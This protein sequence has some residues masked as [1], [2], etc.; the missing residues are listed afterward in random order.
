M[1]AADAALLLGAERE[2]GRVL[3]GPIAPQACFQL[4]S[5]LTLGPVTCCSTAWNNLP[6]ATVSEKS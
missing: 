5:V 6:G 3:V 2:A 4:F 1:L